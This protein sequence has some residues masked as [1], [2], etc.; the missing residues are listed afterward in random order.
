VGRLLDLREIKRRDLSDVEEDGFATVVADG[1]EF[2]WQITDRGDAP[3]VL[4]KSRGKFATEA[5]ARQALRDALHR[6]QQRSS[7]ELKVAAD[8]RSFF[9]LTGE[10]GTVLALQFCASPAEC[11]ATVRRLWQHLTHWYG[12]E[13]MYVVENL[14]LRMEQP[15]DPPLPVCPDPDCTDCPG[16][17]PYSYRLH[18]IL[19][20][21]GG[22]FATMEFRRFVEDLLREETPAHILPKICW[23][24]RDDMRRFEKAYRDWLG[25]RSGENDG[26]REDKLKAFIAALYEVRN[27]YPA[28]ILKACARGEDPQRFILGRSALG[29]LPPRDE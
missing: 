8:G 10:D 16:D 11:D 29:T 12:E 21:Y 14:L 2:V 7:Y 18:V 1:P 28:G 4:L 13:G 19:P 22:R 24:G 9:T 6:G 17:D 25:I 26:G 5:L 23:I 15:G 20:A 27:V 3:T